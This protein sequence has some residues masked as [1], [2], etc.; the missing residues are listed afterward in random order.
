[1]PRSDD[2]IRKVTTTRAK[3][4]VSRRGCKTC[5]QRRIRC[6]QDS[7]NCRNC[8]STG[9]KCD[10]VDKANF[11]F[12]NGN[13][14]KQSR[15]TT[16]S[17]SPPPS[18]LALSPSKG[19]TELRSFHVF[20]HAAGPLFAANN[21]DDAFWQQLVPAAAQRFEFVWDASIAIGHLFEYQMKNP[22]TEYGKKLQTTP[23][24]VQALKYYSRAVS[25]SQQV[26]EQGHAQTLLALLSCSLFASYEFQHGNTLAGG[27]LLEHSQSLFRAC[28]SPEALARRSSSL[29]ESLVDALIPFHS[30]VALA[31]APLGLP[32]MFRSMD[33]NALAG[34]ST[35]VSPAK[36]NP[37][38]LK[39]YSQELYNLLCRTH[40]IVRSVNLVK[41]RAE[42]TKR[43]KLLSS[44][45]LSH[46]D[47]WLIRF[48]AFK[49]LGHNDASTIARSDDNHELIQRAY[50]LAYFRI[51]HISILTCH[52]LTETDYDEH[53][54]GFQAI[55]EHATTLASTT[56][57]VSYV[58]STF[59]PFVFGIGPPLFFTAT[60]CRHPS[61][62]RHALRLLKAIP[63]PSVETHWSFLPVATIAEAIVAYEEGT[64]GSTIDDLPTKKGSVTTPLNI[65]ETNTAQAV[66]LPPEH[67]RVHHA[68]LIIR[69]QQRP[70]QNSSS[71]SSSSQRELA[72]RFI[73][74][75]TIEH[76]FEQG[77]EHDQRIVDVENEEWQRKLR[78]KQ[79]TE[80]RH[81]DA[82][83]ANMKGKATNAKRS[84]QTVDWDLPPE[85]AGGLCR[86]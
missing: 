16:P 15:S 56:A 83:E 38:S 17:V 28:V 71:S 58:L 22:G 59:P 67:R 31:I 57:D 51:A 68:Q 14:P 81:W 24:H 2:V 30:K 52:S 50:L 32:H 9:R 61:I 78:H 46:L 36:D 41:H 8:T 77:D 63:P 19:Q 43:M 80:Q 66:Q 73:T 21:L 82:V 20:H 55:I 47:D 54:D 27:V 35:P 72:L 34:H 7:P 40:T 12:V 11:I 3:Y 29:I 39:A 25:R 13:T 84:M 62:R 10:G 49:I 65:L 76:A 26:I 74:Y 44:H 64:F 6:D 37:P 79:E 18:T 85:I 48:S 5:K 4:S 53:I 86:R 45:L 42:E 60:R 75:N 33:E 69:R 70:A 23:T 1:M